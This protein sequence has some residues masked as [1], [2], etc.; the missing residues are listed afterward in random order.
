MHIWTTAE[1]T[2]LPCAVFPEVLDDSSV[3]TMGQS[4]SHYFRHVHTQL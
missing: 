1:A 4:R 3:V 2:P